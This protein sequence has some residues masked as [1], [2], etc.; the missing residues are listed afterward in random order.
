MNGQLPNDAEGSACDGCLRRGMLI[1]VLSA[2][3]ADRL[4]NTR[5]NPSA[6]LALDDERLVAAVAGTGQRG[7]AERFLRD[8]DPAAARKTVATA[9]VT[10][11][12]HHS[13]V[14]PAL[15]RQ[16]DDM[17]AVLFTRG[18][19]VRSLA[20]LSRGPAVAIVGSRKASPHGIEMA[21]QLGRGLAA[22][23][24]AVVS[25]LALG[26]DA[27]AHVGALEGDGL[28]IAVLGA[29]PDVV[30]PRTNARL[31][32]RI[33]ADG[34]LMSEFPP[35][36]RPFR[37]SF[38]ARN[39]I[40]AGLCEATVV[41]EAAE[42]SGSLITTEVA[43][44]LGRVVGAVPGPALW[45]RARGSNALL[46]SGAVVITSTE[47]VLD[48]LYGIG[49]RPAGSPAAEEGE[50]PAAE[51][52]QGAGGGREVNAVLAAVEAGGGVDGACEAS[53]L[54]AAE[55]RAILARMEDSGRLRRDVL[56]AYARSSP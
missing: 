44:D 39:R 5:R 29:G 32:E 10:P 21:R 33:A 34:L 15:L 25:G 4:A 51:R 40:M 31:H 37:W 8:F 6:V 46:R 50:S 27:S 16:L 23:G 49:V 35:G 56:G 20:A 28:P 43:E 53:G 19:A 12:C 52:R 41:V 9:G 54:E 30:Y 55:V 18:Q 3:I 13:I 48:E 22:A 14:F 17:P 47:D 11:I 1:G 26:V 7:E 36:Q 42:G 24:I 2:R 38:P 45:E